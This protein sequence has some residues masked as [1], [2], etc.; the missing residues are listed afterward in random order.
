MKMGMWNTHGMNQDDEA[1][2]EAIE[3]LSLMPNELGALV[4]HARTEQWVFTQAARHAKGQEK[5]KL[6]LIAKF[7]GLRMEKWI[8]LMATIEMEY[9]HEHGMFAPEGS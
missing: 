8:D 2:E 9:E 1:V 7:F 6:N 4:E 5:R 3:I